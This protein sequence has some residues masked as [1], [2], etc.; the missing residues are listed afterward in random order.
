M[1]NPWNSAAAQGRKRFIAV[2][3]FSDSFTLHKRYNKDL[4]SFYEAL[5]N[6]VAEDGTTA[7]SLGFKGSVSSYWQDN[8]KGAFEPMF[9]ILL[10]PSACFSQNLAYYGEDGPE[11]GSDIH[12]CDLFTEVVSYFKAELLEARNDIHYLESDGELSSLIVICPGYSQSAITGA[13]QLIWSSMWHTNY[14]L[15]LKYDG[16]SFHTV[17]TCSEINSGGMPNIG[18]FCHEFAHVVG[19][20]DIYDTNGTEGGL[21]SSLPD[22]YSLMCNGLNNESGLRPPYLTSVEKDIF[23]GKLWGLRPI[24]GAQGIIDLHPVQSG[25]FIRMDNGRGE[26]IY[27]EY[28][29]GSGWD[30]GLK[31]DVLVYHVDRSAESPWRLRAQL[32]TDARHPRY[33]RLRGGFPMEPQD[34]EGEPFGRSISVEAM[35]ETARIRIM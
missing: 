11:E 22:C 25:E 19:L 17:M 31:R 14:P 28:R 3:A 2:L 5:L 32:N 33:Y 15:L 7:E 20:P 23:F 13:R 18:P 24:E 6:G 10:M 35:G 26:Y 9:D 29:D 1:T 12:K 4:Y 21:S 30:A 16:L 34:W 8:S 27:I